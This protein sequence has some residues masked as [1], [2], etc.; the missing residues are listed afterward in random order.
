MVPICCNCKIEMRCEKNEFIVRDPRH[1]DFDSTYWSSD[2]WK[3][4]V[5]GH[6]IATGRGKQVTAAEAAKLGWDKLNF[7][8]GEVAM[9]FRYN[10]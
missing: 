7:D 9:E 4:P 10:P 2:K 3:C 1:G 6:E 8:A 5:C